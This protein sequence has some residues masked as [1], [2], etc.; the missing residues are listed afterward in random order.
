MIRLFA[1]TILLLCL[2][3]PPVEA[4]RRKHR[5]GKG[6]AVARVCP[7]PVVRIVLDTVE[8]ITQ[9]EEEAL[10]SA[11]AAWMRG[12]PEMSDAANSKAREIAAFWFRRGAEQARAK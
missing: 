8:T 4:R 11:I 6:R 2:L 5:K 7:P 10:Q 12:Q 1:L 3:A 9:S